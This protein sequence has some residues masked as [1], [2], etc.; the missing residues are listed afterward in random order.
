MMNRIV[1]DVLRVLLAGFMLA[2]L[3]LQAIGL[4]WLSGVL[5]QD[6]P[7]EAYMRWP[8]LALSIAGLGCV[9]VGLFSTF[10]LLGF[11]RRGDVFSRHALRWV[12]CIIGASLAGSLVCVATLVY[13]SFTVGGPPPWT[14][15]LLCGVLAG[16]GI[17]LLLTV[18]R[19]LLMQATTLR[20]D[21]EAVI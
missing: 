9:Q 5:A 18:M 6:L 14:L 12:H 4:P 17:A 10:R 8:I 13:Q 15:L 3:F 19:T 2:I 21:M 20:R 7:A 16:V 1:V 11:T